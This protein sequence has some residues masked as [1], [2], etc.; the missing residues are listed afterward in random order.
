VADLTLSDGTTTLTLDEGLMPSDEYRDWSP[1]AQSEQWTLSGA[2][3][4]ETWTKQAGAP[5]TLEGGALWTRI[6]DAQRQALDLM[7]DDPG[8]VLTLT[9]HD[10]T[11]VQVTP[12]YIDGRRPLR[13]RPEPAVGDSPVVDPG[14]DT[15]WIIDAIHFWAI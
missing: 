6:T 11:E 9:L 13:V 10:D 15:R 3:V 2:L 14:S 8:A 1:V 7:T 4:L 5:L 12:R